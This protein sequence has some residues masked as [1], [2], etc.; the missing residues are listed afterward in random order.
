MGIPLEPKPVQPFVG[1]LCN[2]ESLIRVVEEALTKRFGAIE[3]AGPPFPWEET[4]FYKEETG[5]KLLRK[6]VSHL[7]LIQPHRLA[8][9]KIISQELESGYLSTAFTWAR[10]FTARRRSC[11]ITAHFSPMT[12]T[13]RITVGLRPSPILVRSAVFS[14]SS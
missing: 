6:F 2:H 8:E 14:W 13:T 11:F 10:G 4:D 9:I 3:L 5:P 1:L 12:I 7:P